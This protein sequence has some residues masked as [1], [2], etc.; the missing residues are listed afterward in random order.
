MLAI[1]YSSYRATMFHPV[2]NK[3]YGIWLAQTPWRFPMSLPHRPVHLVWQDVAVL[4]AILILGLLPPRN[5]AAL[6]Y[7]PAYS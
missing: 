5:G 7:R 4:L 2:S 1:G 3:T 6:V